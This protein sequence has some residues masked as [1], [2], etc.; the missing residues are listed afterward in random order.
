MPKTNLAESLKRSEANKIAM[1]K[2]FGFI[3]T[4]I[5]SI[6]RGKLDYSLFKLQSEGTGKNA[7]SDTYYDKHKELVAAGY[8]GK[9][10][11]SQ[12]GNGRGKTG[13]T[14]MAG[15]LIQFFILY[16]A[17]PGQ[18]FLDPFMGQGSALQVAKRMGLHYYGYDVSQDM[19]TYA[20]AV[21]DIIDDGKTTLVV[22]NGDSRYPTEVPDECGDFSFYSPPYWDIEY[23]G[24]EDGQLGYKHSYEEFLQG[25]HDVAK[26]WLPKFKVGAWHVVNV[27]DFRKGGKFYPYHADVISL[28][29]QAGWTLCD[30]WIISGTI[31]G[32]ARGFAV[33]FNLKRIAPKVHEY[34]LVFK[35]E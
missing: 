23:Y 6:G 20:A 4:S 26:A 13:I 21:R 18:T 33:D 30:T 14:A 31:G 2:R 12:A 25:L 7:R 5:L 32:I 15:E 16:Y 28:Y 1:E 9:G 29:R 17:K 34:G 19:Y 24:E 22:I 35:R 11:T 10:S 27:N 8:K 3:P